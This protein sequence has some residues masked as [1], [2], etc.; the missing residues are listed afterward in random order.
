MAKLLLHG[1]LLLVLP[2]TNWVLAFHP[3]NLSDSSIFDSYESS[4]AATTNP[5]MV[6]LTLIHGADATQAG[7]IFFFPTLLLQLRFVDVKSKRVVSD[8]PLLFV[9][10][11]NNCLWILDFFVQIYSIS[12]TCTTLYLLPF[13]YELPFLILCAAVGIISY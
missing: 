7:T 1:F 10:L 4:F 3:Y 9:A 13:L 8:L 2:F 11:H 5:L 6:G 12:I